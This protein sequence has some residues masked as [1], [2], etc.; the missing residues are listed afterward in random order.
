MKP[1]SFQCFRLCYGPTEVDLP[2]IQILEQK[3]R[4]EAHSYEQW[5][6]LLQ[7]IRNPA[8]RASQPPADRPP[9]MKPPT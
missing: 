3:H 7:A 1:I 4:R 8:V 9:S 6:A 5:Q 2:S